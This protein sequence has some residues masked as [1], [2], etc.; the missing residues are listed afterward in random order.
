[1]NQLYQLN[2]QAIPKARQ[3]SIVLLL[4]KGSQLTHLCCST[5]ICQQQ[6]AT[7]A[8]KAASTART[9]R[10]ASAAHSLLLA[11]PMTLLLLYGSC[12]TWFY[13]LEIGYFVALLDNQALPLPLVN[14][15][16]CLAYESKNRLAIGEINKLRF[17]HWQ[18]T[19]LVRKRLQSYWAIRTV[20]SRTCTRTQRP[21]NPNP[22][23]LA[24]LLAVWLV[25][26]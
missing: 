25:S 8:T 14:R 23:R 9:A 26:R 13:F 10:T 15:S 5:T 11:C 20:A 18:I 21:S 22:Y 12:Q 6:S 17:M 19:K 24:I 16:I 7:A 4:A 3:L 1:M 2:T